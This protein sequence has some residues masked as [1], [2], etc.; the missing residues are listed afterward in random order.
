M[1]RSERLES[2]FKNIFLKITNRKGVSEEIDVMSDDL[3]LNDHLI[4]DRFRKIV[5][6]KTSQ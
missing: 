6:K 2:Y 5:F 1:T 3:S 4:D